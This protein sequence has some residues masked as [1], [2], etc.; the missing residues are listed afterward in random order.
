MLLET[1]VGNIPEKLKEYEQGLRHL[2]KES[3]N[4]MEQVTSSLCVAAA[5]LGKKTNE[6]IMSPGGPSKKTI[7]S[8][9]KKAVEVVARTG[10]SPVDTILSTTEVGKE[11]AKMIKELQ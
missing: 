4:N 8:S 6:D 11:I 9:W 2:I 3:G 7:S 1:K 10:F 5:S